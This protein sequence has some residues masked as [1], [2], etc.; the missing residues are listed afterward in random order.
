MA[1]TTNYHKFYCV[2]Q[3]ER[4][5]SGAEELFKLRDY[6]NIS[7]T[8]IWIAM[9]RVLSK[10]NRFYVRIPSVSIVTFPQYVD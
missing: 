2:L 7:N 10:S 1:I 4:E 6:L 8:F 3:E 9:V 5:Y